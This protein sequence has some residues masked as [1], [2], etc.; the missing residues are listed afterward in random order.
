MLAVKILAGLI[1]AGIVFTG[2]AVLRNRV[3][4][5]AP[6]GVFARI[7]AYLTRNVAE[8]RDGHP[9]PELRT[10]SFPVNADT[11]YQRVERAV[12]SLGW[13]QLA[14]DSSRRFIRV[15]VRTP[16][17]GFVDDLE[18]R[19]E[20]TDVSVSRL[21]LRSA[22]RVGRGDL[23]ANLRHLLDLYEQVERA[24]GERRGAHEKSDV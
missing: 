21:H 14:S 1:M 23:G 4:V 6:P 5:V 15:E 8:T 19:V 10:R 18:A 2:A 12:S 22:S 24:E 11:L 17:L 13:K 7:S 9:F 20:G 16:L 3:P